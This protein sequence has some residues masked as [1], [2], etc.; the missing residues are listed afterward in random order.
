[1]PPISPFWQSFEDAWNAHDAAS[2]TAHFNG[3][4]MFTFIDGRQFKGHRSIRTFYK[5]T[6]ATMSPDWVHSTL[7][8][9]IVGSIRHG[10][11]TI[12]GCKNNSPVMTAGYDLE[13]SPE[14]LLCYLTLSKAEHL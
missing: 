1:M 8:E 10:L 14:G 5:E 9:T 3:D 12:T 13:L 6:F 11:L 4:A 7:T 2:V